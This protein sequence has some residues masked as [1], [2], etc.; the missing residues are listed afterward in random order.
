MEPIQ[1][2]LNLINQRVRPE[3]GGV[4]I[5]ESLDQDNAIK[6]MALAK[7]HDLTAII[8]SALVDGNMLL[9]GELYRDIQKSACKAAVQ[10][11]KN[12]YEL[13]WLREI[14]EKAQIPFMP[15]KGAIVREYYPEPWL[16][17][18]SDIDILVHEE[19]LD[20]AVSLLI[21]KGCQPY[22]E[23][24]LHE[25]SLITPGRVQLELHFSLRED[26]EA[27]DRVLDR[28]WENS[29]L[30]EGKRYEYRPS[31]TF[32]MF[33]LIAHMAYHCYIGGSGIR[34]FVDIGLLRERLNYDRKM[35]QQ[36]CCQAKL[37]KFYNHT[38]QLIDVWFCGKTHTP[39]SRQLEQ[40]VVRGGTFGNA[41]NLTLIDQAQTGS[42]EK[43]LLKRIFMPYEGL[44]IQYPILEKR[45]WLTPLF[46][47][48]RWFRIFTGGRLRRAIQEYK[49]SQSHTDE[50]ICEAKVFLDN[51]GLN[52]QQ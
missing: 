25:I 10:C 51:L 3:I 44:K 15:L 48:V 14:L 52:F 41:D 18:S 39:V 5:P 24:T 9:S 13:Q 46:Q 43:R 29:S 30:L 1:L 33:H 26:V 49:T 21:S 50:Q 38:L 42:K 8:G 37:D 36:L 35:L 45:R 31:D 6:L 47:V 28:V 27:M 12:I 22:R 23:K 19:D 11:E 40:F 32:L 34:S 4:D 16:R 7:M 2:F 20:A 17:S